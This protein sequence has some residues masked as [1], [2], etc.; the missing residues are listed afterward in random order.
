M[1]I[2][3]SV[4]VTRAGKV[5]HQRTL[6]EHNLEKRVKCKAKFINKAFPHDGNLLVSHVHLKKSREKLI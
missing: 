6:Y 2:I 4:D 3:N 5:N 1:A